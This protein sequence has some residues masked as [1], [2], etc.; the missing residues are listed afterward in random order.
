[1]GGDHLHIIL[2][3]YWEPLTFDL[4]PLPVDQRW[5]RLVDTAQ[6]APDDFTPPDRAAPLDEYRYRAESRSVVVLIAQPFNCRQ[7]V[8][9]LIGATR[10]VSFILKP[11]WAITPFHSNQHFTLQSGIFLHQEEGRHGRRKINR[12]CV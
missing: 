7:I 6:P 11:E 9:Q 8:S 2:N 4:P 5:H 3:A 12:L 1:M 10:Q